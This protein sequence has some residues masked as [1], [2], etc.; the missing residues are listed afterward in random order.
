MSIKNQLFLL[1]IASSLLMKA[2]S[3]NT[4]KKNYRK[5]FGQEAPA[6][7][8]EKSSCRGCCSATM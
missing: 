2:N 4:F 8:K 5:M 3:F 7:W 6:C 1:L